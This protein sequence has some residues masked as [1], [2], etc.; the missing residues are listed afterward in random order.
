MVVP[1]QAQHAAIDL[2]QGHGLGIEVR[3][4]GE[5]GEVVHG[6]V[7]EEAAAEAAQHHVTR[8]AQGEQDLGLWEKLGQV[9][10][11]QGA[12]R[13]LVDE[14]AASRVHAERAHPPPVGLAL[15]VGGGRVH[16]EEPV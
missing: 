1:L 2:R 15:P 8:I 10:Q 11:P 13:M 7:H 6:A 12:Q 14:D 3:G 4:L 5:V 9:G 16:V